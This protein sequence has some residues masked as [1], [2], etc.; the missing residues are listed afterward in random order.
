[1]AKAMVVSEG[2]LLGLSCVGRVGGIL[3]VSEA[4]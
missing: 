2:L 1:M 4:V 3:V